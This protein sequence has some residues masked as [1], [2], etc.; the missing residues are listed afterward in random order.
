[1]FMTHISKMTKAELVERIEALT[2]ALAESEVEAREAREKIPT[3]RRVPEA[4]ALAGCVRALD[5]IPG[6]KPEGFYSGSRDIP[7]TRTIRRVL[8]AL[9]DKYGVDLIERTTEPCD[10]AHLDQVPPVS[11]AEALGAVMSR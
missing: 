5:G 9:A 6:E 10:R 1:M 11:L 8:V 7:P 4:D 3:I 2:V